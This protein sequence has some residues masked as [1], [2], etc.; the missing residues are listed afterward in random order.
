MY[1]PTTTNNK[2]CLLAS[3]NMT[4]PDRILLRSSP[5]EDT[6]PDMGIL[7]GHALAMDHRTVVVAK[8]LMKTSSMMK[9]SL[10]AG[11][12]SSG[13]DV[14]DIGIASGPAL[15]MAASKGDCAVYVTEYRGY[16]MNS[17]YLLMNPDG[18]LFRLEQIRHLDKYLVDPPDLPASG[19][20]GHVLASPGAVDFYNK[21][22]RSK[23]PVTAECS[24]VLDCCCGPVADSAPQILNAMGA[25]V[26]TLNAQRDLEA[27]PGEMN[28]H[29]IDTANVRRH[30]ES[31][32]GSIG[33]AMN[34]IGTIMSLLDEKGEELTPE[35]VFA[36]IVMFLKP[37]KIAVP[38][39]TTTLVED[40]FMGRLDGGMSLE[41]DNDEP[42]EREMVLTEI[43]A[44]SVCEAVASGAELG[45]YDGGIIYGD[46]SMLPDGI[47][48]A[49]VIA[50][51]A[52]NNSVN[53]IVDSF[54]RYLR[55]EKEMECTCSPDAFARAIEERLGGVDGKP[56]AR[57]G[58]WRVDMEGGWYL[59]TLVRGQEPRLEIVC[60]S[61]DRAYLVGLMEV[62]CDLVDECLSSQ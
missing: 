31:N 5:S 55:D 19:Y 37:V 43:S 52:G 62:A 49:A 25:D 50:A 60:E 12:L 4:Q 53:R 23:V 45:F 28:R 15:A 3:P 40:A 11:L 38:I 21:K 44:G 2:A 18:T 54:P 6:T 24:V 57:G 35:Q 14:I 32:P 26:L 39:C 16:G 20:L 1:G 7:L 46:I 48:T 33:I 22:L 51:M 13:S 34:K 29:G 56:V 59:V 61:R 30:V 42:S 10:V 17:G 58:S 8:D 36:L 27:T 41:P 47:R 9:E